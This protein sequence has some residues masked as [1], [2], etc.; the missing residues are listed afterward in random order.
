MS[1]GNG[2]PVVAFTIVAWQR[3]GV[4]GSSGDTAATVIDSQGRYEL[5]L[6]PG[7]YEVAAAARGLAPSDERAIEVSDSSV[8]VD[9]TLDPGSRIFGR[10]VEREGGAP[11]A[12]AMGAVEDDRTADGATLMSSATTS[13][14]GGFKLGMVVKSLTAGGGADDAGLRPGDV[15]LAI[16]GQPVTEFVGASR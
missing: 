2:K 12:G 4:L 5:Q 14:D 8:E 1:D 10:V 16:D 3:E 11:I 9:F 13:A 7:R 6:P 15:I